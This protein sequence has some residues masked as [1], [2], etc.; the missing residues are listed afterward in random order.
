MAIKLKISENM[1]NIVSAHGPQVGCDEDENEDFWTDLEDLIG[2]MLEKEELVI[3]GDLNG[4]VGKE[5]DG[6]S[7]VHGGRGYGER[8]EEGRRILYMAQRNDLMVCNTR[9]KKKDN[10]ITCSSGG[11]KSQLDFILVK[12]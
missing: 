3:E 6:Y 9:Y 2:E 10:H 7:R 1:V 4:Y 5:T 8:N 12:Q 11:R